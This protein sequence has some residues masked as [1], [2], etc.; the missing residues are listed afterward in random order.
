MKSR[1]NTFII[2]DAEGNPSDPI[3]RDKLI[4]LSSEGKITAKTQVRST[5]LKNW[6][7]AGKLDF[8]KPALQSSSQ[9]KKNLF[10][11][12]KRE[13]DN[14]TNVFMHGE[15]RYTPATPIERIESAVIDCALLLLY[16]LTAI[17]ASTFLPEA[18]R[19]YCTIGLVFTGI[20]LYYTLFTGLKAQT[21]GQ[22]FWGV[23]VVKTDAGPVYL[24]RAFLLSF[25]GIFLGILSP[26]LC[27]ILP[28]N[29]GVHEILSGCRVVR[30]RVLYSE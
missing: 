18:V 8:L 30:T 12:K 24:G 15:K 25:F 5:L 28:G 29:R 23:M 20:L 2:K 17:K 7:D 21:P 14:S 1:D 22:T 3:S 13:Q 19:P 26:L 16:C 11:K 27:R 6:T 9:T 10:G 4:Q